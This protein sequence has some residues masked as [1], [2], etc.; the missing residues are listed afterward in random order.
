MTE[1]YEPE[2]RIQRLEQWKNEASLL[3]DPLFNWGH[4]QKDIPLGSSVTTE[5]LR[6]AKKFTEAEEMMERMNM[7]LIR[8]KDKIA[9]LQDIAKSGQGNHVRTEIKEAINEYNN[10]KQTKDGTG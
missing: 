8:C 6:R 9:I 2:E 10:Y 4:A 5:I 1:K 3:L 7:L